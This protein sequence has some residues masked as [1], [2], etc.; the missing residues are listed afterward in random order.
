L[1]EPMET[2]CESSKNKRKCGLV[3]YIKNTSI[4]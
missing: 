4:L 3:K 1:A 2:S